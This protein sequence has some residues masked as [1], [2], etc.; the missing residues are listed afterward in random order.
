VN[1]DWLTG[2]AP[3]PKEGFDC[4]NNCESPRVVYALHRL[5]DGGNGAVYKCCYGCMQNSRALNKKENLSKVTEDFW[6]FRTQKDAHWEKVSKERRDNFLKEWS[7][8]ETPEDF[9]ASREWLRVRY[10]ALQM[11]FIRYGHTCLCCKQKFVPLHVDH[12]KPRSKYP[13]LAL[14]LANLQVLC[15]DCNIGKSN[16]DE[17]D[18]REPA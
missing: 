8:K 1:T 12:I 7:E 4:D 16:I 15:A 3:L 13:E 14:D 18:F 11:H 9:Y 2:N 17:T 10:K 5:E 6:E